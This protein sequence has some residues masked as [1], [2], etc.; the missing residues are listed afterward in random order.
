ML[1]T[2]ERL[3][4][5]E[6]IRLLGKGGMGEVY[7]ARQLNPPRPV[8]L[9]VLAP[10]L[11][12]D[13][14]A[15]KRFWREAAIPAQLDH[16]GIVRIIATGKTE[17]GIAYY[18]MQLVRGLT[19]TQLIRQAALAGPDSNQPTT[20]ERADQTPS[21]AGAEP[22]DLFPPAEPAAPPV[23]WRYRQDRYRV[24]VEVGV[25]AARALASAHR[26]GVLHRDVKPSNLMI[27]HHDQLYLVDF[28]LTR[29]LQGGEG[30]MTRPGSVC[31]T[32]WY[33][34]PEQARGEPLDV[35]SD[36]YS[37][38]VALYELATG[39]VGPFTASRQ[40]GE[41]VL[42]E[43]RAGKVLPLRLLAPD[44]PPALESVIHRAVEFHP[45][46][47]YQSGEELA[48]DLEAA[49]KDPTK[50]PPRRSRRR[51]MLMGLG[52][53]GV[54]LVLAAAGFWFGK[55]PE[56]QPTTDTKE[57][58]TEAVAAPVEPLPAV[59]RQRL[60][61]HRVDLLKRNHE[62]IWGK[63]LFGKGYYN[64][65]PLR[66]LS[67]VSLPEQSTTVVA[68][69]D[70]GSRSFEFSIDV[71][72]FRNKPPAPTN[73]VGVFFGWNRASQAAGRAIPCFLIQLH[74]SPYGQK[75][76]ARISLEAAL[77][78]PARG[79]KQQSISRVGFLPLDIKIEPLASSRTGW[80]KVQV[81]VAG[82]QVGVSVDE[83][84]VVEFDCRPFA[85]RFGDDNPEL[86]PA[87]AVGIWCG[88]GVGSF[89]EAVITLRPA[90][91]KVN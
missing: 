19:L 54:A 32:P 75:S 37:L 3:G 66:G 29:A 6:I 14:D 40:N 22:A 46:R 87:G 90:E 61:N 80:R 47:R 2:H 25:Q 16:P 12:E 79:D 10:W 34:S 52:A 76:P 18:A 23:L 26:Q 53:I 43:V 55:R 44:I 64:V 60:D 83:R 57:E 59:L 31:G 70:P 65:M 27:D 74:E 39:G 73:E 45:K 9:K 17:K 11:A 5:F 88:Q 86:S 20:V 69:D 33:M 82:R 89:R 58:R 24:V 1:Q 63:K 38:G 51:L 36:L 7:E 77:F 81:K 78:D 41:A 21:G 85:H 56:G 4:D 84:L 62:P 42:E 48:A 50:R 30:T 68:L 28:G 13:E 35:R 67:L 91:E 15:L 71:M 8:A 72:Q 49:R